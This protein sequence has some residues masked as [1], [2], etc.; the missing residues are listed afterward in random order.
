M[1]HSKCSCIHKAAKFKNIEYCT[2]KT[3]TFRDH[4]VFVVPDSFMHLMCTTSEFYNTYMILPLLLLTIYDHEF[5]QS[6]YEKIVVLKVKQLV[7]LY[8]TCSRHFSVKVA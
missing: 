4:R 5:N 8:K 3:E 1:V 2:L 7:G 6:R